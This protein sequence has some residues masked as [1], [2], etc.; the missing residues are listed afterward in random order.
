MQKPG[1][2]IKTPPIEPVALPSKEP[3]RLGVALIGDATDLFVH[4]VK[5]FI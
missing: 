4:S 1:G 2:K 5:K 3:S